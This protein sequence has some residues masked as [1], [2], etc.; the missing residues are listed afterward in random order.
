MSLSVSGRI[1]SLGK[2]QPL[3]RKLDDPLARVIKDNNGSFRKCWGRGLK[4]QNIVYWFCKLLKLKAGRGGYQ[5]HPSIRLNLLPT[6]SAHAKMFEDMQ[7]SLWGKISLCSEGTSFISII[8]LKEIVCCLLPGS[9]PSLFTSDLVLLKITESF[10]F[11]L[12]YVTSKPTNCSIFTCLH[13][14]YQCKHCNPADSITHHLL[15]FPEHSL[16]PG[17]YAIGLL[18]SLFLFI[19]E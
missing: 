17:L 4:S 18:G 10:V 15:A 7:S 12:G 13:H 3:P 8:P 2:K 1:S 11:G 16:I 14:I 19:F 5:R 9:K 6:Q